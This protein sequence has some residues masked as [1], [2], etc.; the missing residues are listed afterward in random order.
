MYSLPEHAASTAADR[1]RNAAG[2]L[3]RGE[4][5]TYGEISVVVFGHRGAARAVGGWLARE[6]SA[7]NAHRVLRQGGR[8]APG[9]GGGGDGPERCRARLRAEGVEFAGE[10]ADPGHWVAWHVLQDRL[11]VRTRGHTP[12]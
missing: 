11:S 10:A 9:W 3:R 1:M 2:A 4:W 12:T 6:G 8:V 7:Q 5:T